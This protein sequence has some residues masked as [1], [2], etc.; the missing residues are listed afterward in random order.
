MNDKTIIMTIVTIKFIMIT[1]IKIIAIV[2][3]R[4]FHKNESVVILVHKG[5]KHCNNY[6]SLLNFCTLINDSN[7]RYT[8]YS[9][10]IDHISIFHGHFLLLGPCYFL[11]EDILLK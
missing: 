2:S 6:T 10:H 7:I 5:S 4:I 8:G 1:I 11:V 9:L 3:I